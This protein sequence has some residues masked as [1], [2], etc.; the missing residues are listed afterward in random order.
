MVFWFRMYL[1]NVKLALPLHPDRM[2]NENFPYNSNEDLDQLLI[3]EPQYRNGMHVVIQKL[4]H[5][6]LSHY[7]LEKLLQFALKHYYILR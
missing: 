4:L 5:F 6:A 7:A 1:N 3:T 2:F